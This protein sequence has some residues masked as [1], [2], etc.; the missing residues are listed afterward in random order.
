MVIVPIP[1]PTELEKLLGA[2]LMR[3]VKVARLEGDSPP[4]AEPVASALFH[5][6]EPVLQ[7]LVRSD[8]P[9]AASLAAAL[10]VVPAAAMKE[11]VA[12][13]RM[14]ESLQDNFGEVMNVLS[15]F[16]SMGGRPFRLGPSTCPPAAPAPELAALVE[17][18]DE[19]RVFNVEVP[20][21]AAGRL[22]FVTL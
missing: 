14:D 15:R 20:G 5:T 17:A 18:S 7:V 16:L 22:E 9:L 10:S 6:D 3:P 12:S 21:Y 2:L 8:L 1:K 19:R 13:K 4:P 11:A